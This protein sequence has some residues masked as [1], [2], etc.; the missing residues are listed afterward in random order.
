MNVIISTKNFNASDHMKQTVE[1][2]LGRLDKYFSNAITA[3]VTLSGEGKRQKIEATIRAN[4]TIFRAEESTNDLYAAIDK[5]ADK[6]AMQMSRFKE[7]LQRK[8]KGQK[9]TFF[10]ALPDM[11]GEEPGETRIIKRKKFDLT[12]MS[13]DEAVMQMELLGHN[14]Y[15]FLNTETDA[16][17]VIYR[18]KDGDYGLL[19]PTD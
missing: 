1:K 6:L 2:K 16:V 10:E 17:A 13:V 15:I 12:P 3:H 7:K 9:E 19:E 14:F 18:R 11:G 8:H 5:V 4:G